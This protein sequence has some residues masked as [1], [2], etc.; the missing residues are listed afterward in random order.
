[1]HV[2]RFHHVSV[3]TRGVPLDEVAA[4]YQDVL[5]LRGK[6]RPDIPGVPGR[7]LEVGDQ[8]LHV[9]DVPPA[10]AGIDPTG[11]HYCAVVD[12]LDG[13]VAELDARGIAYLRSD[14]MTGAVQVWFADPAGHTIEL[15]Q[16]PA[17]R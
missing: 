17:T 15:Q 1:M 16:D 13:A 6:P 3:N 8:E 14:Q 5:G 9:V 7:W 10:A 12:D 4:F 2:I 11:D